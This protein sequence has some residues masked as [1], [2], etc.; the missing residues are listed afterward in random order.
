MKTKSFIF[1]SLCVVL[2]ICNAC[3]EPL[4]QNKYND[5]TK[6]WPAFDPASSKVG[7]INEKGEMVIPA[8]FKRAYFFCDGVAN[9]FTPDDKTQFIDT[10]GN[11]VYT[12]PEGEVCDTY[13]YN[14]CLKFNKS[15][16]SSYDIAPKSGLYDRH[17]NVVLPDNFRDLGAMS[18]EGLVATEYGYFNK[19]GELALTFDTVTFDVH[20]KSFITYNYGDFY[21]GVAEVSVS[22]Y[23]NGHLSSTLG[24]INTKG[25]WV[26]DTT[27]YME[28]RPVGG[29]LLAYRTAINYD[30]YGLMDTHGN[31]VTE[32]IFAGVQNFEDN[33]LLPVCREHGKWGYVDKT[34][35]MRIEP[36]FH[37]GE[38]FHEGVAWAWD[39]DDSN[40]NYY[41]IDTHGNIL[42]D[43]GMDVMPRTCLHNGLIG[44]EVIDRVNNKNVFKYIDKNNHT[45]YSWERDPAKQETLMTHLLLPSRVPPTINNPESELNR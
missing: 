35:T 45:I 18:K 9:V 28:L 16:P 36:K 34:G 44:I 10:K 26:I 31:K 24:A 29:G 42:I 5:N 14:G 33:D 37:W 25:E 15:L 43:F 22:R 41:L 4:S 23:N 40:T 20:A 21:D 38:P 11:V 27:T 2:L 17:F 8:Q 32:P 1:C 39:A 13:F 3:E 6:L 30:K 7:Y 19:K 12:L